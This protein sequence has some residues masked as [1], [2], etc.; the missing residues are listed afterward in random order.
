MYL[1]IYFLPTSMVAV[2]GTCR[3]INIPYVDPMGM[4]MGFKKMVTSTIDI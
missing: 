2:Y 1:D 4:A 3:Y